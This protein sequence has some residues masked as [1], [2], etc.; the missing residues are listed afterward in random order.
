VS[1]ARTISDTVTIA[2]IPLGSELLRVE[3]KVLNGR[4]IFS[5]W[6]FWRDRAGDLKP[7]R[8]GLA[9]SI[10][11]LPAVADAINAAIDRAHADGLLKQ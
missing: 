11:N 3:L 4:T 10:E 1:G 7:G 6:R 2:E 9:C 5:A 8:H